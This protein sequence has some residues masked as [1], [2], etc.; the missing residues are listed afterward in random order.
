M[1]FWEKRLFVDDSRDSPGFKAA[2]ETMFSK[3]AAPAGMG[4][5]G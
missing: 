4:M 5:H 3:G 1:F 2:H